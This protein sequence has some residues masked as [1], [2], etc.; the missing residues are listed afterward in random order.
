ML[1]P[2]LDR[3]LRGLETPHPWP[4]FAYDPRHLLRDLGRSTMAFKVQRL[5]KLSKICSAERGGAASLLTRAATRAAAAAAAWHGKGQGVEK[6]T[7]YILHTY[8]YNIYHIFII[9][10]IHSL[11]YNS[12]LSIW[13]SI[14]RPSIY[15]RII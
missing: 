7:H 8:I 10:N 9:D 2:A 15:N 13:P 1:E 14:S 5:R 4:F 12:I 3:P 6:Q 11:S